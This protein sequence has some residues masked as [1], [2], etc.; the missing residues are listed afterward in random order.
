MT[1]NHLVRGMVLVYQGAGKSIC[2]RTRIPFKS[3]DALSLISTCAGSSTALTL[4]VLFTH[5]PHDVLVTGAGHVAATDVHTDTQREGHKLASYY[6][7]NI[8]CS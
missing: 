2:S 6:V 3:R 5:P 4:D 8:K 7:T 1:A